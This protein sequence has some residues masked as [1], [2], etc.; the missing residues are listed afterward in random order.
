[1]EFAAA[2]GLAA[3]LSEPLI[4]P[5]GVV[6]PLLLLAEALLPGVAAVFGAMLL[7]ELLVVEPLVPESW[8]NA[9]GAKA[10]TDNAKPAPSK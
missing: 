9:T 1:V 3:E 10:A 6:I 7:L 5:E 8:A 4:G 2:L